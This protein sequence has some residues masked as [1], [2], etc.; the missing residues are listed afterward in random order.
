[1]NVLGPGFKPEPSYSSSQSAV[2]CNTKPQ[3][4]GRGDKE[5]G[6]LEGARKQYQRRQNGIRAPAERGVPQPPSSGSRR[7]MSGAR[8][9][10]ETSTGN[11]EPGKA[12][13]QS[14]VNC[15]VER[16]P[17]RCHFLRTGPSRGWNTSEDARYSPGHQGADAKSSAGARGVLPTTISKRELHR[18]S[19]SRP[20][21]SRIVLPRAQRQL[22][23]PIK[24]PPQDTKSNDTNQQQD[25]HS[26]AGWHL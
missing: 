18:P 3:P 9:D 14:T 6:R 22:S 17:G 16:R 7:R 21:G 5:P 8:P 26:A 11:G 2:P 12:A 24:P 19:S 13:Q 25:A 23:L 10:V 20:S 15:T 1:M 4:R